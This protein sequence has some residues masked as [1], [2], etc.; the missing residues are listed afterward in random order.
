[1][2]REQLKY[3][4]PFA[5][6]NG[7]LALRAQAGQWIVAASFP[8]SAFALISI[9]SVVMALGTLT[10]QPLGNAL[11]SNISSLVGEGL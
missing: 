2:A 4:L 5:M 6:A 7:F 1:L 10:R 8:S 9:A 3:L 11:L